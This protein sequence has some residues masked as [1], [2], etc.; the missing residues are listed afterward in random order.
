MDRQDFSRLQDAKGKER[1]EEDTRRLVAIA[2]AEVMASLLTGTDEWDLF[3]QNIQAVVNEATAQ[4]HA[5]Q[6][7]I[8]SPATEATDLARLR[9]HRILALERVRILGAVMELPKDLIEHGKKA[10]QLIERL[11]R[12]DDAPAKKKAPRSRRK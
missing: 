12:P 7:Q 11:R 2:R 4:A 5:F 3:L 10:R 9:L 8:D 6:L 1:A